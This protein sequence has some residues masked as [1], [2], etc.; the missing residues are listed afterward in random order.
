M[1]A[2]IEDAPSPLLL[3]KRPIR[4]GKGILNSVKNKTGSTISRDGAPPSSGLKSG[5]GRFFSRGGGGGASRSGGP[6]RSTPMGHDGTTQ[7]TPESEISEPSFAISDV[8]ISNSDLQIKTWNKPS[9]HVDLKRV[10]C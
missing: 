8:R 5:L 6:R 1:G 10:T 4:S 2:F 7:P 9:W 3:P